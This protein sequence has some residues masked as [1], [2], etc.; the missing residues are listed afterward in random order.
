MKARRVRGDML[1]GFESGFFRL[2][3]VATPCGL[4]GASEIQGFP[5]E[6]ARFMDGPDLQDIRRGQ[7]GICI[8]SGESRAMGAHIER[9]TLSVPITLQVAQQLHKSLWTRGRSEER[10]VGKECRCRLWR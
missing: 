4:L 8:E 3:Q 10:R 5:R 1:D 6:F 7:H 9:K 2:L